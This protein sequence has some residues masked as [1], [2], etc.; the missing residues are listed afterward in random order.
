M[1]NAWDQLHNC[2]EYFVIK[3]NK[4]SLYNVVR[5]KKRKTKWFVFFV[6][7]FLCTHNDRLTNI[8]KSKEIIYSRML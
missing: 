3:T 5:M 8:C 4:T 7:C 2:I 1:F 6:V